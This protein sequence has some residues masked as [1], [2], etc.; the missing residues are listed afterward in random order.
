MGTIDF[1]QLQEDLK[2]KDA[3]A[4]CLQVIQKL[5]ENEWRFRLFLALIKVVD[6]VDRWLPCGNRQVLIRPEGP[7]RLGTCQLP[8]THASEL[9]RLVER[10]EDTDPPT[11]L[12]QPGAQC[13]AVAR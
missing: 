4:I 6:G 13:S 10:T 2:F 5:I 7:A 8:P 12:S 3:L 9:S 11:I 1:Y